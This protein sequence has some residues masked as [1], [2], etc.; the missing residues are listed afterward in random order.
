MI[1]NNF[2]YKITHYIDILT[3]QTTGSG[4]T[5]LSYSEVSAI[6]GVLAIIAGVIIKLYYKPDEKLSLKI[7]SLQEDFK[8]Y[9]EEEK[10]KYEKLLTKINEDRIRDN[11]NRERVSEKMDNSI[12]KLRDLIIKLIEK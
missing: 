9:K 1:L 4:Y 8:K 6:L 5:N 11:D 3:I 7:D 2:L 10:D 12:E